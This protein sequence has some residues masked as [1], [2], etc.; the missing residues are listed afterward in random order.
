MVATVFQEGGKLISG[1]MQTYGGRRYQVP[2]TQIKEVQADQ[3]AE[4]VTT[5]ETIEY[6]K[7]EIAKEL[8]L[9]EGHLQQGCK[10]NSKA[11]DCC[12]KHP[13]K[14]E[15]LAQ[16]TAG[17]TPDPVFNDLADWIKGIASITTEEASA[18]GKYDKQ[19]SKLA[20]KAREFRKSIMPIMVKEVLNEQEIPSGEE[21]PQS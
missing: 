11:C 17:M 14:I 1:L 21:E 4:H 6:Q 12:E 2:S 3:Q 8:M 20:I 9:L 16:E 18:S 5:D 19:Y 7:R 13:I 15:G 10:I